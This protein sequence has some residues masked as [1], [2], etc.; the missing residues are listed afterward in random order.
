MKTIVESDHADQTRFFPGVKDFDAIFFACGKR[1]FQIQMLA[2]FHCLQCRLAMQT[3]GQTNNH[4]VDM[5]IL[6]YFAVVGVCTSRFYLIGGLA[7]SFLIGIGN[8]CNL[9]LRQAL[10]HIQ[11]DRL[12]ND[13]TA[14]NTNP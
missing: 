2:R 12:S 1:F 13:S 6:E 4:R 8:R 3:G 11:M 14:K 5:L 9:Y 7:A 10:Q